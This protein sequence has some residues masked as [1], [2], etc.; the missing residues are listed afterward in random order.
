MVNKGQTAEKVVLE[1]MRHFGYRRNYQVAKYFDVTPQTLSGWI[2]TGEIPPK[3]M[4]KYTT[5]ILNVPAKKLSS[6]D[7]QSTLNAGQ[8]TPVSY[9]HL[10]LPTN[11]EV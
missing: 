9:T 6:F 11:R 8:I 3:H 4:M 5:E 1:V 10:T 7:R 2:K